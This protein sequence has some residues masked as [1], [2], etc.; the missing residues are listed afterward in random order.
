MY[1]RPSCGAR[2]ARPENVAFHATAADARAGGL[3]AVQALQAGPAVAG[4]SSTRRRSPS[5]A[6]SSSSA[7][8]RPTL[9]AAGRARRARAAITSIA[10]SRTITGLTPKAYAAAHRAKRVREELARSGTVTEAIYDAGYN[11]NGR[12]YEKS[13]DDA[14]HDADRLSRRRQQ[15]G[16]PVRDRRM[17]ARLD[18][19]RAAASAACAR[20]CSATIPDALA[21][22]LQDRFPQAQLIGGDPAFEQLVAQGGG[23]RRSAGPRPGPAARRARHGVP[24]ARLAGAARDPGRARPRATPTSP[25]ASARPKAVRAVAQACGANTLAVAIPCHRVVRSDGALSGYRWGVERKRALLEREA[26]DERGVQRHA[27][28]CEARCGADWTRRRRARCQGARHRAAADAGNAR[29]LAA[30][31]AARRRCFAAAW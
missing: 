9:D 26:A 17:L 25:G 21:R 10:C 19:G 18:P 29:A 15:S 13:N 31:Y 14:R 11:S 16:D 12:F 3:P 27:R 22:D 8:K 23:L 24:A 28:R 5:C 30:L 1:C 7:E 4:P 6:G 20:S 2:A